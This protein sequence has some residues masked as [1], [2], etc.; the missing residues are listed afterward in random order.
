MNSANVDRIGGHSDPETQSRDTNIQ[1][2]QYSSSFFA[3]MG[4]MLLASNI[5]WSKYGFIM[6]A[7][8]SGQM[9]LT[10]VLTRDKNLIFYSGSVFLFVDCLGVYR[11][12]IQ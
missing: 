4:G 11:W 1:A 6:L 7:L 12:L 5:E 9:L 3:I 8:G 2:L 10:S